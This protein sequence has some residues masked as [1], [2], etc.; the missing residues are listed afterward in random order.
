MGVLMADEE[1]N[2]RIARLSAV[3]YTSISLAAALAF[4]L[5]SAALDR[6]AVARYG[7]TLWVF[8]LCMIIT[9]PTIT[10]FIK[11]RLKRQSEGKEV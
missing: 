8:L 4:F 6:N 9:M 11:K 3:V 7:G 5:A 1:L 10:P 2:K